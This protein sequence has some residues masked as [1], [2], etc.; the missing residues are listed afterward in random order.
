MT[1]LSVNLNKIALL[2]NSRGHDTPNVVEFAKKFI[3]LGV[4]G[5]TIHPRPDERHIT[6]QDAIDLGNLIRPLDG[7][8]LNIEGYP[9]DEFLQLIET[10][11]PD[12]TTLVPDA[13]DQITSDHGFD[14]HT[15]ADFLKPIL[16]R[17]KA[18]GT[19][20]SV[21][22]D[23]DLEQVKLA[24]QSA[25]DR[26]ELYTEEYAREFFT[27]N[28]Q[29]VHQRYHDA[30]VEAQKLGLEVN[31]GHD[32]SLINLAK[33]LT[34]PGVLEVSIGHALVTE[35]LEEGMAHVARRY[36]DICENK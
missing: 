22:L 13:P 2:R 12:Q 18:C 4:T 34:I 35:C 29:P 32:L 6:R 33:F 23:P 15:Q 17:L 19:R 30:A 3:D 31:A 11:K 25:T 7:I 5:I 16:A 14:F 20:I 10:V 21:F 27:L 9:S 1:K 26:I 24:A 8:E 36:L 28:H